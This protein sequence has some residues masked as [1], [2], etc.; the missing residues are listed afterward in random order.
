M[1][2][3]GP[4]D[5]IK[6]A[7]DAIGDI[8]KAEQER[9]KTTQELI[10]AARD[11][12]AY[13]G[14][15]FRE[16]VTEFG[17]LIGDTVGHWR[18]INL[19]RIL[20]NVQKSAEAG[21]IHP[22]AFRQLGVGESLRLIE[23]ASMEDEDTIQGLWSRL[24]FNALNPD[25]AT[26]IRKVYV[27]LLKSLSPSEALLL[28]L[29]SFPV[30][31][32]LTVRDAKPI[33]EEFEALAERGWRKLSVPE[34]RAATQNLVR[35][36]CVTF[37]PPNLHLRDLLTPIKHDPRHCTVDAREFQQLLQHIERLIEIASGIS[38]PRGS[39]YVED[40]RASR[41]GPVPYMK[42]IPERALM[43]TPLGQELMH[44]CRQNNKN[45]S[46]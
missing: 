3:D 4:G 12:G 31:A 10:R 37:R 5:I 40:Q 32:S 36:R 34:R 16:A 43:L 45:N 46:S 8:A 14:P 33:Y 2:N 6:R 42:R 13:F 23:A 30:P 1:N 19:N 28:D 39:L 25:G 17:R 26:T 27:D 44:A 18:F 38:E 29:L 20:N 35:L 21:K 15:H 41:I 11:T 22:A 24:I 7:S 9:Q